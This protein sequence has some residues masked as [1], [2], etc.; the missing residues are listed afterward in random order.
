MLNDNHRWAK[1]MR[2]TENKRQILEA[3][4]GLYHNG[5]YFE[6]GP[7]PYCSADVVLLAGGNVRNT[8]RTLKLMEEQGLVQSE[9]VMRAQLCE[10]PKFGHYPRPVVCYWSTETIEDDQAR[11]N[12]WKAGAAERQRQ[13]LEKYLNWLTVPDR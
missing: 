11:A 12:A 13:A 4:R 3:L 5:E 1:L 10:V 8:S 7:P 6:Y 9:T 2:M